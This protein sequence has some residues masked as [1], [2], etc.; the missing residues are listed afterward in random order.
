MNNDA[1]AATSLAAGVVACVAQ[2][3]EPGTLNPCGCG[4]K[5]RRTHFDRRGQQ[6]DPPNVTGYDLRFEI[7]QICGVDLRLAEVQL[8]GLRR[9]RPE[10]D[11]ADDHRASQFAPQ[12]LPPA[13]QNMS[14][15]R[16]SMIAPS[17]LTT[18]LPIRCRQSYR[19]PA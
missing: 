14:N 5:S 7:D 3:A 10:I 12:E 16:T 4:F 6:V 2:L 8:K 18:Q 1:L 19:K 17:P 11:S 9:Q 15:A 13:P